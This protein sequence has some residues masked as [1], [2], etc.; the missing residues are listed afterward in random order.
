MWLHR[1]VGYNLEATTDHPKSVV[2]EESTRGVSLS[3][4]M[5]LVEDEVSLVGIGLVGR[6]TL[7][8]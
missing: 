3:A 8:D 2:G 5:E 1:G 4:G 7:Q 6:V